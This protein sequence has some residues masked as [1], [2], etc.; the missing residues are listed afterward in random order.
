MHVS[1]KW[2]YKV[3]Q[4]HEELGSPPKADSHKGPRNLGIGQNKHLSTPPVALCLQN[5]IPVCTALVGG[6]E[7][8]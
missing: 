7:K 8:I 3:G 2:G 1:T 4:S 6:L 5:R